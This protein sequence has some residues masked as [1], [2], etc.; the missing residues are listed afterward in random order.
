LSGYSQ[1]DLNK[2]ANL[3]NTRPRKKLGFP[4][5]KRFTSLLYSPML[6]LKVLHFSV[7]I[8]GN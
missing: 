4:L 2:I 1:A 5:R 6:P 7:E 3:L 8:A